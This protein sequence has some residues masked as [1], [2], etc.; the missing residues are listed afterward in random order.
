MKNINIKIKRLIY[1]I[2]H[3]YLT[4]NNVV[5]VVALMIAAGWAWGSLEMMSRNYQLQRELSDRKRQLAL[6][7]VEVDNKRLA[8]KFYKTDEFLEL[9]ARESLNLAKP[10]ESML[11]LRVPSAEIQQKIDAEKKTAVS[12]QTDKESNFDQWVNFLFGGNRQ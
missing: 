7:Q 9:S 4:L 6:T 3:Q 10:G 1:K 11:I 5:L 12:A 8:Q 2:R